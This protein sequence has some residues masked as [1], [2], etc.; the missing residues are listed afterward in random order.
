MQRPEREEVYE[1]WL[2]MKSLEDQLI[3]ARE[4]HQRLADAR[5][6]AKPEYMGDLPKGSERLGLISRDAL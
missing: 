1:A 5:Y 4:K 6:H 2:D 3:K